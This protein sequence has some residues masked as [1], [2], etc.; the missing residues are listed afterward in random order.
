[1]LFGHAPKVG[2]DRR[3][4]LWQLRDN[5]ENS[6]LTGKFTGNFTKIMPIGEKLLARTQQNQLVAG[7]FP[8]K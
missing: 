8:T 6:L 4:I 5:T 2:N 1:M 3:E 7:Q